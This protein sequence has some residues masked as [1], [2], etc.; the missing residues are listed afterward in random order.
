MRSQKAFQL[1]LTVLVLAAVAPAARAGLVTYDI[2]GAVNVLGTS[3]PPPTNLPPELST[4]SLLFGRPL[5][6][7]V[8]IETAAVDQDPGLPNVGTY[9][10]NV[11]AF[12]LGV[13]GYTFAF[14][15]SGADAYSDTLVQDGSP[16]VFSINAGIAGPVFVDP[17]LSAYRAILSLGFLAP[18]ANAFSGD[19]IPADLSALNGT[20][21]VY[22]T[23][24]DTTTQRDLAIQAQGAS[25]TRRAQVPEPGTLGLLVLALAAVP[26]AMRQRSAT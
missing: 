7:T 8:T 1:A 4:T 10:E 24:F 16:D 22:V 14:D 11:V 20:W 3:S 23:L 9:L 2:S 18:G 25:I 26:F 19:A 12:T 17:Q 6:A 5:S 15:P 13:N 21:F